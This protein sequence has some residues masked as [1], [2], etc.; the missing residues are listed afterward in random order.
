M[1]PEHPPNQSGVPR[2]RVRA[3]RSAGPVREAARLGA[4]LVGLAVSVAVMG[5]VEVSSSADWVHVGAGNEY[6]CALNEAGEIACWGRPGSDAADPPAGTF[7]ALDVGFG[8]A[9][10]LDADGSV[11][12]W[13]SEYGDDRT[14]PPDDPLI[15]VSAGYH[16][17]CGILEGG[18]LVC[19]GSAETSVNDV[20]TG[21]VDQVVSAGV[22]AW[23]LDPE[24]GLA[25]WGDEKMP[26]DEGMFPGSYRQVD[27][28]WEYACALDADAHIECGGGGCGTTVAS[29]TC[30]RVTTWRYPRGN[31]TPAGSAT[32]GPLPA[33]AARYP[34]G[35]PTWFG[36]G[37]SARS[38]TASSPR[39][40]QD[41][42]TPAACGTTAT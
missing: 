25:C 12:C 5:C 41:S 19:W 1:S 18:D 24:G 6:S 21:M 31:I 42:T 17:S 35:T 27:L 14:D 26:I 30:L 13:G 4:T 37:V 36:T 20:P 9:C 23:A 16:N 8:T 40:P 38:P 32:T 39:S 28:R 10:V 29:S 15:Q 22:Y 11:L 7:D 33:G 3:G 34:R 2:A